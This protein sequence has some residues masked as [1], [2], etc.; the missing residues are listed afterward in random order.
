MKSSIAHKPFMVL[1][2]Y[3]CTEKYRNWRACSAEYTAK[4]NV[5]NPKEQC[6]A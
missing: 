6:G 1:G 3:I 2:V 5:F 4:F